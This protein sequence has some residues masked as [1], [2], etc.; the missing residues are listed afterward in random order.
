[1]LDLLSRAALL[2]SSWGGIS[3]LI[4]SLNSWFWG[5]RSCLVC[6]FA[7]GVNF[8]YLCLGCPMFHFSWAFFCGGW[9]LDD[10]HGI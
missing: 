7:Y 6:D 2:L 3:S 1:M 4:V 5:F 10:L 9:G 8:L